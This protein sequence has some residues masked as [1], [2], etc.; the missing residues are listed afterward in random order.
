MDMGQEKEG[1]KDEEGEMAL[2]WVWGRGK[3]IEKEEREWVLGL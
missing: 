3:G 2:E 1:N